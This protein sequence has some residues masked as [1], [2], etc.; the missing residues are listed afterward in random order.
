MKF[1][2]GAHNAL[3]LERA[4]VPF[5]VSDIR[6][7]TIKKRF[8]RA[9]T[10]WALDSGGFSEISKHGQ[11]TISPKEYVSNVRKYQNEI[12]R[13]EWCAPQDWMCEPDIIQGNP[14]LKIKGTKLSI[15]EHIKRTVQSYLDLKSLAPDLPFIPVIQGWSEGDYL[16]CMELYQKAGVDLSSLP[17]VGLGSV[18]RRQNTIRVSTWVR[19]WGRTIRLH[20]FGF[21]VEGLTDGLSMFLT[22]SD[23]L[24]WSF[25]AR[26]AKRGGDLEADQNSIDYA[27][28]WRADLL[29]QIE[30]GEQEF[31]RAPINPPLQVSLTKSSPVDARQGSFW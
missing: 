31:L 2:L 30:K 27:L 26:R 16:D 20:G 17:R 5:F 4:C 23:S 13:L 6:L 19:D 28:E 1:Y 24:A 25:Q 10:D 9:L 18:C 3:F 22:S 11:W 15:Q 29:E 12:G 21:K 7:R 8:P 14:K